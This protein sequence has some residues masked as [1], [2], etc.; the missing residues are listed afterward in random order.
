MTTLDK[1]TADTDDEEDWLPFGIE[2]HEVA[3]FTALW[4]RVPSWF[5]TS[6]WEWIARNLVAQTTARTPVIRTQVLRQ[7][8]RALHVELPNLPAQHVSNTL[9]LL[10]DLYTSA[11]NPT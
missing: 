10:Q 8:E 1:G 6:L 9:G 11:P 2:D 5:E 7:A 4:E 3:A